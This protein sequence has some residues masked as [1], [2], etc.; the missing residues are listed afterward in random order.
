M[1]KFTVF[2]GR[3]FIGSD[4]VAKIKKQDYDC[5]VIKRGDPIPKEYMGTIIYCAGAGDCNNDQ[6]N[7][8]AANTILL[9]KILEHG[10]FDRLIYISSYRVYLGNNDTNENSDIRIKK[11]DNRRLFNLTKL[12]SEEL[13]RT[14][15]K[16]TLVVRP[17]NVYGAAI[18]SKL[19]LPSIVRDAVNLGVV[20]MF[21]TPEYA[22]D[23]ISV[24][25]L[26]NAII[27]LCKI[28]NIFDGR[29]INIASGENIKAINLVEKIKIETSCKINWV[30]SGIND[31]VFPLCDISSL[32][33][34][35]NF[36]PVSVLNNID[37]MVSFF[38]KTKIN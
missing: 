3:G 34:L 38:K 16:K 19:F 31:D 5:V 14:S 33:K 17:S 2:G 36:K 1:N 7:V 10:D 23:Y 9:S 8:L 20:N 6:Y 13:C 25:D 32:K 12:T 11:S 37:D 26:S 24:D 29:L 18:E 4:I 22:K 15:G 35:I 28:E 21:V 30:N 27:S